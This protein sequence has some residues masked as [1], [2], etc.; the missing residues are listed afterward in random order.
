MAIL[1]QKDSRLIIQGITGKQAR[2]HAKY[3]LEYGTKL[4]GG[5][6]PGKSG[7]GVEGVPVFDTLREAQEM[8][9]PVDA[10]LIFTP[11][12]A[13]QDSA[14]EAI[15][16]GVKVIVILTEHVPVHDSMRIREAAKRAGAHIIGPNTI[17]VISP[18]KSKAGVMPGFVFKEGRVGIIS[19][20]GTLTYEAASL[21]SAKGIGQSTCVGIGG[22]PIPGSSFTDMLKL[23]KNDP[24]TDAVILIGEIG[25]AA[26]EQAA[27]YLNSVQYG[28]PVA[29]FIAG[30]TAPPEKKMGHAGAIVSGD[31]GTVQSK[32][33]A[34]DSAG[35]HTA[36]SLEA[37]C[38][39]IERL[40]R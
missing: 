37:V 23:F 5:V 19:R 33:K 29:A 18:G 25:G 20:S 16:G 10:T 22:D 11:P 34:L 12:Y 31:T 7:Q 27:A 3:H 6:T 17:G 28:K 4:V 32:R 40:V 1:L 13:V 39:Q 26:E 2:L 9:G 30:A 21:L 8:L 15:A 36:H 14:F 38:G 24:E 35:V